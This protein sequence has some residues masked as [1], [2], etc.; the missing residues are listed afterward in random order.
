MRIEL[1]NESGDPVDPVP[2]LVVLLTAFLFAFSYGPLYFRALGAGAAASFALSAGAFL[3]ATAAA[4]RRYVR[5]G[6]TDDVRATVPAGRR[7]ERL[8]Y[9]ML[10]GAV[11]TCALA[12]P[13]VLR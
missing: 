6:L 1:T 13:L 7:M 4:Y 8:L 10:A 2:V 3:L 5:R 9:A 11:L 12:L